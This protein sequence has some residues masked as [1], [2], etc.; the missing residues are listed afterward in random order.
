[1]S[2]SIDP[3]DARRHG[4]IYLLHFERRYHHAGH[5]LGFTQLAPGERFERHA[6][7]NGARLL[8][9]V[10]DA[11]IAWSLVRLWRGTRADERR[12]KNA[13]SGAR[14][15]PVCHPRPRAVRFLLALPIDA[16]EGTAT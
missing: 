14:L 3:R 13:G 4:V 2:A 5:Y 7:G 9:V 8:R 15:C 6:A 16:C 1:M 11:G 12:L 10:R